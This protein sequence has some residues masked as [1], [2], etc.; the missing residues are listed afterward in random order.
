M[1]TIPKKTLYW[2]LEDDNPPVRNLTKKHLQGKEPTEAE[3]AGVIDYGPIK[4]ILSLMKP[5]GSWSDPKKP[6]RKYTGNYWQYIFLCDLQANPADKLMQ[7]A[8]NH[9]LSYQLPNGGFSHRSNFKKHIICLT[10]NLLRSLVYF[11][12]GDDQAV[13]KGIN[14]ITAQVTE[15]Q[16]TFCHDP[17]YNLLPDCQMA[18]TKVLALYAHLDGEKRDSDV[19]KAIT[20][21]E[22]RIT[23]NKIFQYIPAGTTEYK[24]AIKGKKAAEI[25]KIKAKMSEQPEK[26]KK[27]VIK[28]GW[29]V[30][31][32]PHSY[33]SDALD[34]LYW[35][36]RIDAR[37]RPE[38]DEA[39]NQVIKRMNSSKH[40]IN[41]N[42][43]RNPMLVEI[44]KNKSPSK[45][46]TFR[47][48]YVLKKFRE[49]EIED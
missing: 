43:F 19:Q 14:L 11:G 8:S 4:T 35:L 38:F 9:I 17:I 30:F 42:K 49:L 40:W 45:W 31:G 15:H 29:K 36:A 28:R 22:E 18:L 7:K 46:L 10:A 6:Y 39:I 2:L 24:K 1:V 37:A 32:F 23:E 27:T 44:E 48:C 20:I 34:T 21:I 5:D 12:Y 26:M 3:L 33:T 25:R 47:A 16:G 41:E 13:Q